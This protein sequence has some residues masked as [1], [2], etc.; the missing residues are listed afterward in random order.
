MTG[1]G[2]FLGG[3]GLFLFGASAI[4]RVSLEDK[5]GRFRD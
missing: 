2:I 1:L 5:A 3:F 4:W